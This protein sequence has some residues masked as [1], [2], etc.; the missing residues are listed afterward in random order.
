MLASVTVAT[1]GHETL[2]TFDSSVAH[3]DITRLVR[4]AAV[5]DARAWEQLIDKH[6]KLIW[7]ITREFKLTESDAADVFQ[8]TWM[9]LIEHITRLDR[10]GPGRI[11]ACGDSAERV[12]SLPGVAQAPRACSRERRVRRPRGTRACGR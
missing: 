6:G 11:L 1:H 7:S 5:G 4:R 12:P 9:R 10:P 8:I 2:D 3:I